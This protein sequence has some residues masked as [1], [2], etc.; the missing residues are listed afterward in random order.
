MSNAERIAVAAL[1]ALGLALMTATFALF[2]GYFDHGLFEVKQTDRSTSGHVAVLA[3][4]SD[5]Q[6]LSSDVYFVLIEDHVPSATELLNAY[7]GPR[8]I[9]AA[10]SDCLRIRWGDPHTLA[11]SCHGGSLDAGHIE[12][13]Q[14]HQSGDVTI[15]YANIPAYQSTL[16]MKLTGGW[17]TG[18]R[19]Q[20]P[21]RRRA[22][23]YL[24]RR[25][26]H[27][28]GRR[29]QHRPYWLSDKSSKEPMTEEIEN[30]RAR[31]QEMSQKLGSLRPVLPT[32]GD[33]NSPLVFDEFLREHEWGL[34]L[35]V[36]CDYLLEPTTQ[37]VPTAVI[38]QI[39]TLHEVM[40]IQDTCVADLRRKAGQP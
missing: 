7:H 18:Y 38:Q 22:F 14:Q 20:R 34:A 8:V 35:H 26:S 15:T 23:L 39:Q 25:K 21:Q 1:C 12:N 19:R 31:Q 24:R 10:A 17:N 29:R 30:Q 27:R 11:V 5:H 4:R 6:A 3:K 32:G 9:F 28:F 2:H 13:V 36:V 40:G 37:A 33:L 16:K